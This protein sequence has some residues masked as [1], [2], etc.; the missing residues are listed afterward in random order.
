VQP[1]TLISSIQ[2]FYNGEKEYPSNQ[3]PMGH[4][5]HPRSLPGSSYQPT[6]SQVMNSQEMNSFNAPNVIAPVPQRY[7]AGGPKSLQLW[8]NVSESKRATLYNKITQQNAPVYTA[9]KVVSE[10]YVDSSYEAAPVGEDVLVSIEPA[11]DHTSVI[12]SDNV[13]VPE[14]AVQEETIENL[15]NEIPDQSA[16]IYNEAPNPDLVSATFCAKFFRFLEKIKET[17]I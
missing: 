8:N 6:N 17:V 4:L 7:L 15:N 3:Q 10:A 14:V 16:N 11:S 5:N 13:K 2:T 1:N 12:E 9:P